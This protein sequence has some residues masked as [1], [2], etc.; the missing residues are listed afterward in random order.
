MKIPEKRECR[1]SKNFLE[2]LLNFIRRYAEVTSDATELNP[3]STIEMYW[4]QD[5]QWYR[6]KIAA[7]EGT[8]I[9][10]EYDDGDKE[11]ILNISDHIWRQVVL[12]EPNT[13]PSLH[14]DVPITANFERVMKRAET[15]GGIDGKVVGGDFIVKSGDFL[16]LRNGIWLNDAISF[17]FLPQY[18]YIWECPSRKFPCNS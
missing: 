3:S 16:S 12:K 11:I 5:I 1:Q 2:N 10:I 13:V 6:D 7:I 15:Y 17:Q 9:G 8:E 4:K 18:P 14:C